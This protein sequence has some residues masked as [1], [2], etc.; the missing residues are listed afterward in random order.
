MSLT[1]ERRKT[2]SKGSLA[3]YRIRL[4]VT[5]LESYKCS[6]HS[7]YRGARLVGFDRDLYIL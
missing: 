7:E 5:R 4:Y 6:R 3:F 2:A 1:G